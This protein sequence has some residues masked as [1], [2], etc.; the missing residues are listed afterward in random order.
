MWA[1]YWYDAVLASTGFEPYRPRD[2]RLDGA[3]LAA[4]ERSRPY[5]ERLH[6]V[7]VQL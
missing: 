3:A 1:P 2:T 7:R 5:Y 4:A 6:A